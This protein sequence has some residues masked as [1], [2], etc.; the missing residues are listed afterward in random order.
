MIALNTAVAD[1]L[2][3]FMSD[4]EKTGRGKMKKDEAILHV[5]RKYISES[6]SVRFEGNGYSREWVKEAERRGLSNV[7]TAAESYRAFVS[8]KSIDLFERNHILNRKELQSRYEIK[9]SEY[10][11]KIQIESRVLGDLAINHIIP[12]AIKYQNTLISS[13][14]DL[15]DIISDTKEFESLAERRIHNIKIIAGHTAAIKNYV[16]EMV[17]ERKCGNTTELL[18]ER[19]EIYEQKVKPYLDKIREHIDKLELIVDNEIWPLPKYREL[20]FSR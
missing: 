14:K 16:T 17:E 2:M 20:L 9:L 15:K 13:V 4:I 7:Q 8:T 5:L 11:K 19:V 3:I 6:K 12:I 1:Q 18:T 10:V